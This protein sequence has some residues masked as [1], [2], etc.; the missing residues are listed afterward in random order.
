M[1]N[2]AISFDIAMFVINF[3]YKSMVGIY[4]IISPD[5]KIYIGQSRDIERR[6]KEHKKLKVSYKSSLYYSFINEGIKNHV[7]LVIKEFPLNV[8]Q[9]ILNESEIEYWLYYQEQG[10]QMLNDDYPGN[11]YTHNFPVYQYDLEGNFVKE[12]SS[13]NEAGR[14]LG[15]AGN[16]ICSVTL[17]KQKQAGG[18]IWLRI[19][20]D[21]ITEFKY[22]SFILKIN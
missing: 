15:I 5:N 19:K 22:K 2:F 11:S 16:S 13:A 3:N 12:W 8:D 14:Q 9:K 21:K 20:Q 1:I 4:K 6:F 17:G 10:F 7:F 18:F